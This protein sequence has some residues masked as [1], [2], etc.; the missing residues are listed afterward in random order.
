[1]KALARF[2]LLVLFL[3]FAG[4]QASEEAAIGTAIDQFHQAAA[5]ADL[6]T[7]TGLMASDFVFLG[8]DA[9]E[10]WERESFISFSKPY[11]DSGQGWTYT[12]TERSISVLSDGETA[13]FDELLA[14]DRLGQCRGS[15]VLV[16]RDDRWL[17]AQYNLSVP[18][19]NDIVYQVANSIQSFG[20]GTPLPVAVTVPDAASDE[21]AQ[22][23]E[24]AEE[25]ESW[26]RKRRHKTNKRADC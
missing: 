5:E 3:C 22:T 7:Y 19:P 11:F 15:G 6:D 17:L 12:P 16:K 13:F 23:E 9:T 20:A 26:C 4:A 1:M 21:A 24:A 25:D 18:V 8:T 14:H 2:P 10:R